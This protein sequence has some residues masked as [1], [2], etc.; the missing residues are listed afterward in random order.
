MYR[1]GRSSAWLERL[2]WDQEVAGSNPVAPTM[3]FWT[4]VLRS[5][6]TDRC[7]VGSCADRDDRLYRHNSVAFQPCLER[8]PHRPESRYADC[9]SSLPWKR[10]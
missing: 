5:D 4:C 2:V 3:I 10:R 1:P 9:F 7:Y 6:L 8:S